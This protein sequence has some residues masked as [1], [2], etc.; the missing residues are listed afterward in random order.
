MV[1]VKCSSDRVIRIISQVV[2][3]IDPLV[4]IS[5]P[6]LPRV[7]AAVISHLFLSWLFPCIFVYYIHIIYRCVYE[8]IASSAIQVCTCM[9]LDKWVESEFSAVTRCPLIYCPDYYFQ[10]WMNE[11]TRH[12]NA[13]NV[14]SP[15]SPA[16][17]HNR[18]LLEIPD[19]VSLHTYRW[20]SVIF[21]A[22]RAQS[23]YHWKLL[24]TLLNKFFFFKLIDIELVMGISMRQPRKI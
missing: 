2:K 3:S 24:I 18:L 1:V 9:W 16:H 6:D 7:I 5:C 12:K 8:L 14:I 20:A 13:L 17:L 19:K 21:Y 4:V 23:F 15:A 10:C 22:N 11:Y